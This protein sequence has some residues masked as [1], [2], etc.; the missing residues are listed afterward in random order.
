MKIYLDEDI[1]PR[2]AAILRKDGID[3]VSAHEVDLLQ[4]ADQAQLAY[5]ATNQ[6]VCVTRNRNDFIQLTVLFYN[7]MRPHCGVLIVPHSLPGNDFALLARALNRYAARHPRGMAPYT[8][9]FL[10]AATSLRPD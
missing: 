5:A 6:R 2:V 9:D 4:V 8:V 10:T 3:A 1:S 7:D